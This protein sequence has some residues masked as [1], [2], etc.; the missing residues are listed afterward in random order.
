[1]AKRLPAEAVLTLRRRLEPLA[2]RDPERSR[3]R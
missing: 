3:L 2:P 1:V